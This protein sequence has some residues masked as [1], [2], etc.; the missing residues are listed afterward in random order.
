M[1]FFHGFSSTEP[2][3]KPMLCYQYM[4]MAMAM[5]KSK[6]KTKIKIK[7][8]IKIK[9][10]QTER[11]KERKKGRKEEMGRNVEGWSMYVFNKEVERGMVRI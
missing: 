4:A 11:K 1:C 6:S 3:E 7:I 10:R 5:A 9:E 2:P 8:K